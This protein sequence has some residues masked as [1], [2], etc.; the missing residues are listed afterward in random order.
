[1][2]ESGGNPDHDLH[3]GT[4]ITHMY[5]SRGLAGDNVSMRIKTSKFKG[6]RQNFLTRSEHVLGHTLIPSSMMIILLLKEAALL[7]SNSGRQDC[8]PS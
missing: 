1:V 5:A 2:G 8:A 4:A 3:A 6:T 7:G